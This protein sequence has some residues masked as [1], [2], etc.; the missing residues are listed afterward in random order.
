MK[1]KTLRRGVG[2]AENTLHPL[3]ITKGNRLPEI[4][5]LDSVECPGSITF[6][7]H[8]TTVR[9]AD[10]QSRTPLDRNTYT[11]HDHFKAN[12][13]GILTSPRKD[14]MKSRVALTA[15]VATIILLSSN[16]AQAASGP[17]PKPETTSHSS[18][19]LGT[20]AL[21]L[22][23]DEQPKPSRPTLD[24]LAHEAKAQGISLKKALDEYA[25]EAVRKDPN[26][27]ADMP[28][29][30][31][32]DP[33]IKVDGI[34]FAELIDL[35]RLAE[36]K[37]YSFDEAIDRYAWVPAV[38]AVAI[39]LSQ[40]FHDDLSGMAYTNGG[41]SLRIGFK[42]EIPAKA[43]ELA[44]TLPG[45]V[46]FIS[47]KGFSEAE[48][49]EVRD[50]RHSIL[51]SNPEVQELIG[52][53]DV[54]TGVIAFQA[55][56][57]T[58]R[59]DSADKNRIKQ[60]LQPAPSENPN[61]SINVTLV[62]DLKYSLTDNYLRGGGYL[63]LNNAHICMAG[64][65]IQSDSGVRAATTAKHCAD[66]PYLVYENHS[67]YDT[68]RTT[69]SRM[70]RASLYDFARYQGG[71]LT[72]T[73]TFYY[74]LNLPRYAIASGVVT[75]L[76]RPMCSFGRSSSEA[77]L[78]ARCGYISDVST[79]YT[80]GGVTYHDNF[81]ADYGLIG[82]DSGGPTYWGGIAYGINSG[83]DGTFSQI[84]KVSNFNESGGFGSDWN[85]W[86]CSTC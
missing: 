53:Y 76:D 36:A 13:S 60:T 40:N 7:D 49:K 15:S 50:A 29:G 45:E 35:S 67:D 24:R 54:E 16:L 57:H 79:E 58:K 77:G 55:E 41:R 70:F 86:I 63:T 74:E 11:M 19:P 18:A 2:A 44:K 73:R 33:T 37:G 26:L 48:L 71:D 31:V 51:A 3:V 4:R 20:Q 59:L 25:A 65:N 8:S 78:G 75:T 61:I 43:I 81:E 12:H 30:P 56:L 32:P 69:L 68:N 14:K 22:T 52:R 84:A 21:I 82:G 64:F 6:G 17:S 46:E 39:Q 62:D 72:Y 9:K 10:G 1:G 47:D 23:R 42:G 85:V 28:D 66:D 5:V 80:S 27:Q 34:P 83:S 38:D